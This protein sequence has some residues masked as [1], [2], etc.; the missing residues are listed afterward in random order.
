MTSDW[1]FRSTSHHE[2]WSAELEQRSFEQFQILWYFVPLAKSTSNKKSTVIQLNTSRYQCA[3]S[4][5]SKRCLASIGK[6]KWVELKWSILFN[7]C[8]MITI[9]FT[10]K[11]E[12]TV[13]VTDTALA[14][15]YA[16]LRCPP[17]TPDTAPSTCSVC[18]IWSWT[19][20]R[21]E[22]KRKW[23]KCQPEA[24]IPQSCPLL[25]NATYVI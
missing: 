6:R 5:C 4:Q 20:R 24:L 17:A 2:Q 3:I 10:V 14:R 12:H 25:R 13:T 8:S 18:V 16:S 23:S 9:N 19:Q 22:E 1:V 21:Y 15:C 11:E 7:K